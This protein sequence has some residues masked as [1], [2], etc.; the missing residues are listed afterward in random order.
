[1][2]DPIEM[3]CSI[4]PPPSEMFGSS[5]AFVSINGSTEFSLALLNTNSVIDGIDLGRYSANVDGLNPS[6][7]MSV[8]R[9]I[10]N[11]YLPTDSDTTFQ[12][13]TTFV[14]GSVYDSTVSDS[15]MTQAG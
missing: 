1:M 12:C 2:G 10:I 9:L 3:I 11:N 14:N 8:I 13:A 4:V 15:P 5:I 7:A 6:P